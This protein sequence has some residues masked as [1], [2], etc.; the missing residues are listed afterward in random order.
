ML[1]A[2]REC[3]NE[4][5]CVIAWASKVLLDAVP[6][7]WFT[8]VLKWNRESARASRWEEIGNSTLSVWN[9]SL[10]QQLSF[11]DHWAL[12]NLCLLW[13]SWKKMISPPQRMC[14][15]T[16]LHALKCEP[17]LE[18]PSPNKPTDRH[19]P[20]PARCTNPCRDCQLRLWRPTRLCLIAF[21]SSKMVPILKVCSN[22]LAWMRG[23]T[24]GIGWCFFLAWPAEMTSPSV[25]L[26]MW[27]D[28]LLRLFR[29]LPGL[30]MC[31]RTYSIAMCCSY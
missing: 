15:L 11:N 31:C 22:H 14:S 27:V 23:H 9:V 20:W 26:Q 19:F 5:V 30:G 6:G 2:V 29:L 16:R 13:L 7:L 8:E 3:K 1:S 4:H 17:W 21:S 18:L 24:L 28:V 12:V 25:S 10:K